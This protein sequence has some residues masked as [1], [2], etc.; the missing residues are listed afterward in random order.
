MG[1]D[2]SKKSLK[3][4]FVTEVPKGHTSS[5][6]E[7]DT[8]VPSFEDEEP[9]EAEAVDLV[10][11]D[12]FIESIYLT[13]NIADRSNSI[14]KVDDVMK[15]LPM[16]MA[17]E[18]KRNTVLGILTSFNLTATDVVSDGENRIAILA[19]VDS[20]IKETNQN[21]INSREAKIE[22]LKQQI[23]DLNKEVAELKE[24]TSTSESLI[25]TE[26]KKIQSLVDFII[27]G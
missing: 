9:V 4:L 25:N 26:T 7:T 18:V 17:N 5:S 20:Q 21:E 2:G 6:R 15:T 10:D 12:T 13:N 24:V 16:E 3:S 14:F 27:G 19:A 23:A 1:K 22:D 8:Y 11:K